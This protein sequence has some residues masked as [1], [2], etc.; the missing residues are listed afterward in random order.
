[1]MIIAN[2]FIRM[3]P[4]KN[5]ELQTAVA[6]AAT[7]WKRW[8]TVNAVPNQLTV[9]VF[10]IGKKLDIVMMMMIL[11]GH[12]HFVPDVINNRTIK[13]PLLRQRFL[14]L[15][16]GG[17]N[18]HI[19]IFPISPVNFFRFVTA[20]RL[21]GRFCRIPHCHNCKGADV[22]RQVQMFF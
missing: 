8:Q 1:M 10:G 21:F 7:D 4:A 14:L 15:F 5:L 6:A 2:V 20:F 3:A 16:G 9:T 18:R 11:T 22:F 19:G 17:I 13:K 12:F